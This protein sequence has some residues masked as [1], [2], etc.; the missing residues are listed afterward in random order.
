MVMTITQWA[1]VRGVRVI[2]GFRR[3][4]EL[5]ENLDKERQTLANWDEL[6]RKYL[7]TP[8]G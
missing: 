6:Y 5:R 3:H 2:A 1:K 8:I 4:L 7:T